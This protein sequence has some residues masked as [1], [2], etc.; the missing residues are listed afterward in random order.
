MEKEPNKKFG[1][2]VLQSNIRSYL[3]WPN[4]GFN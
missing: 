3:E 4:A 2:H 1:K